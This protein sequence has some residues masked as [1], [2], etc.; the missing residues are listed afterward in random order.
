MSDAIWAAIISGTIGL[1]GVGFGLLWNQNATQKAVELSFSKV[2]ELL[3]HQEFLKACI[4]FRNPFI[5][6]KYSLIFG[7]KNEFEKPMTM[8]DIIERDFPILEKAYFQFYEVLPKNKRTAFEDAWIEYIC[9]PKEDDILNKKFENCY[10]PY[11]N[12][13]TGEWIRTEEDCKQSALKRIN[14][15]LKFAEY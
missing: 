8:L 6:T 14:K 3:S 5:D 13:E 12:T 2:T 7:A 15:L 4:K 9:E 1:I 10:L 11:R